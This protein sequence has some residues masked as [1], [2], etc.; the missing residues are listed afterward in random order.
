MSFNLASAILRGRWLIQKEFADAHLPFVVAFKKGDKDALNALFANETKIDRSTIGM[1]AARKYKYNADNEDDDD[2]DDFANPDDNVTDI[3]APLVGNNVFEVSPSTDLTTIP[4]GSIAFVDIDG[5]LLKQGG[6]CSWGMT[7][8]AELF[9]GLKTAKNIDAVILDID[10]PGGQCDGTA[11]LADSIVACKASKPVIAFVDDGM[12][13][14]AAYWVISA[15][16]AI[17]CSQPT[18][19]VGSIGVY[20]TL[21]DMYAW[22]AS[23]GLPVRDIY[24]PESDDKNQAYIQALQNNDTLLKEELSF[25][26][27]AFISAVKTNRKGKVK[28]D[29]WNTGKKYFAADALA[30]GLIDGIKGFDEVVAYA[31]SLI[32]P[33]QNSISSPQNVNNMAFEKVMATAGIPKIAVVEGGFLLQEADLIKLEAALAVPDASAA[34]IASMATELVQAKTD[35]A[36]AEASLATANTTIGTLNA[37]IATLKSGDGTQAAT[38][39][40]TQGD[41][42][43][44]TPVAAWDMPFQQELKKKWDL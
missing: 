9:Y 42:F 37:E 44:K 19:A 21:A 40:A 34:T 11:T 24:A 2:D 33:K 41:K 8:Y 30:Q 5:A 12:A 14:S 36:N 3:I 27:N 6:W 18:D 1:I 43:E 29:D 32:P 13:A 28:G 38:A 10:S 35:K 25:I 4:E 23:E 15:C 39:A 7:D 17:Y 31:N 22:Y 26:A 20:C 16:T